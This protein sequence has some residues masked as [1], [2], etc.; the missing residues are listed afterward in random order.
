M[1]RSRDLEIFYRRIFDQW[2]LEVKRLLQKET[3]P[4]VAYGK[5]KLFDN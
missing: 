1:K 4:A 5:K 3:F 2:K